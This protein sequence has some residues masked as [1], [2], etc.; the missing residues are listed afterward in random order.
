MALTTNAN[1]WGL[2]SPYYWQASGTGDSSSTYVYIKNLGSRCMS[3]N[4][5]D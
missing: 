3:L 5:D 4:Y 1:D 2:H